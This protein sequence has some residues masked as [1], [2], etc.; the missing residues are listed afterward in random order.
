[1]S[2]RFF[3]AFC[4]LL[5]TACASKKTKE[6]PRAL[7]SI[8]LVFVQTEP[9]K[10]VTQVELLVDGKKKMF[11]LDTGAA[12]SSIG[13]DEDT[14]KYPSLGK[15]EARGA[16]GKPK[17]CDAVRPEKILLGKQEYTKRKIKRCE[18]NILGMDLLGTFIFQVNLAEKKLDVVPSLPSNAP[19]YPIRRLR[20]GHI[21]IPA[22]FGE[23]AMDVLF[24]TGADTTVI[25]S[26][27][28]NSHP[29][30]FRLVR[31][32][33]GT[34]AHGHKIESKVYECKSV[35]LGE[36]NLENVEMAAFDFGPFLRG[37]MEGTPVILGNNVIEH[38]RWSFD[39]KAGKW[40]LER[41]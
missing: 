24:D 7:E 4:A 10:Y 22:K 23:E 28:I 20:P 41:N 14:R 5:L 18:R 34:D 13:K 11:L 21:T 9:G 29:A 25:D 37:R 15:E 40:A 3:S 38:A 8:P 35:R 2:I 26:Q 33:E 17:I 36:L 39:L 1:M 31:S 16:S 30:L 6:S 12:S 32:E 19:S 27:F